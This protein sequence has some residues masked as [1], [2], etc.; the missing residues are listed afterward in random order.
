MITLVMLSC[1]QEEGVKAK[2]TFQIGALVAGASF[3]GGIM[4]YGHTTDRTASFGKYI[5][6]DQHT[7][8]LKNGSWTF[9]A[10]G[11]DGASP[12]S[13]NVRCGSTSA[14]LTGSDINVDLTMDSTGCDSRFTP[15]DYLQANSPQVLNLYTCNSLASLGVGNSCDAQ[16]GLHKSY[17]VVLPNYLVPASSLLPSTDNGLRSQCISVNAADPISL[18]ATAIK[19]PLG[20]NAFALNTEIHAFITPDCSGANREVYKFSKGISQ[21]LLSGSHLLLDN[22]SAPFESKLFLLSTL[23]PVAPPPPT[24]IS[25]S[26]GVVNVGG[27][28]AGASAVNVFTDSSCSTVLGTEPYSGTITGVFVSFSEGS[29]TLFANQVVDGLTSACST[30]NTTYIHDTTPPVAASALTWVGSNPSSASTTTLTWTAAFDSNGLAHQEI[31]LFSDSMCSIPSNTPASVGS[32]TSFTLTLSS[33]TYYALIISIDQSGNS[34]ASSCSSAM[35]I[36]QNPPAPAA[37]LSWNLASPTNSNI[38]MAQW[39]PSVAMDVASQKVRIYSGAGCLTLLSNNPVAGNSDNSWTINPVTDQVYSFKIESIDTAGNS[40]FS[41]CSVSLAVDMTPPP[42]PISIT[43]NFP[44]SSPGNSISPNFAISGLEIGATVEL[45]KDTSCTTLQASYPG[46]SSPSVNL[47]SANISTEGIYNF[48]T[49]QIDAA[50]NSS[51]CSTAFA[52]YIFDM[53]PP[54]APII[55]GVSGGSDFDVDNLL[56]D[57]KI[58]TIHW[59]DVADEYQYLISI[60]DVG[61]LTN[62]CPEEIV[63]QNLTSH[64][65][66]NCTLAPGNS[67]TVRL[68]SKDAAGNISYTQTYPFEVPFP[69]PV[70]QPMANSPVGRIDHTAVSTGTELITWGGH[71]GSVFLNSGARFISDSWMA[72]L[73]PPPTERVEHTTVWSPNA[74]AMLMWGGRNAGTYLDDGARLNSDNSWTPLAPPPA[75]SARSQHIAVWDTLR[76][77]MIIWGGSNGMTM[78]DSGLIYD[79]NTNSW[80]PMNTSGAPSARILP[81]YAIVGDYLIIWGGKDDVSAL[82]TGARYH[83]PT[84]TWYPM[85]MTSNPIARHRMGFTSNGSELIIWGGRDNDSGTVRFNTG[86]RYNPISDS[87]IPMTT[88]GAPTPRDFTTIGWN[89][90]YVIA[91]GGSEGGMTMPNDGAAYDISRDKWRPLSSAGAP[92]A[93][94]QHTMTKVDIELIIYGG[95]G[96]FGVALQNGARLVTPP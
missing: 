91:W 17:R 35:T 56:E 8:K 3:P 46:V 34:I 10:I 72:L 68:K 28:V 31:Y 1:S 54:M 5:N 63:N 18:A 81:A 24:S 62:F 59:S 2:F 60:Y 25:V 61:D 94:T 42:A 36:D 76:N 88:I 15:A 29:Y 47:S 52:T 38:I 44:I 33:G 20:G 37:G 57:G 82:D 41:G 21:G 49:K 45:H 79:Y 4:V 19:L 75:G 16:K 43:L 65:L 66:T 13:G 77:R 90:H 11:W 83:L 50:G 84:D 89:G 87:W 53:T 85:S 14:N 74:G 32:L 6:G 23:T 80:T 55:N 22:P 7:F 71:N 40:S 70:W 39:T 95:A 12:L 27:I 78:F 93:R 58:P 48:Y 67:Y 92:A 30:V 86:A 9:Y 69:L 26:G 51:P 73:S 64:T 96:Q